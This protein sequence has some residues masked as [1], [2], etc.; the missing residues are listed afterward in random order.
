VLKEKKVFGDSVVLR[1]EKSK[2][3]VVEVLK[4]MFFGD[5]VILRFEKSKFVV[6]VEGVEVEV[7]VLKE[8]VYVGGLD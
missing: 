2:F 5:S 8:K 6:E 7:G 1:F 3:E 4:G